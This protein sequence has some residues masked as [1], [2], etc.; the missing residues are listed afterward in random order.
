MPSLALVSYS[1]SLIASKYARKLADPETPATLSNF[2]MSVGGRTISFNI[3][4]SI[5]VGCPSSNIS[6][7][8]YSSQLVVLGERDGDIAA[9]HVDYV[10]VV[11]EGGFRHVS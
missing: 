8:S 3:A 4:D 1:V 11:F 6:S 7:T 10:E 5:V 2:R 9:D